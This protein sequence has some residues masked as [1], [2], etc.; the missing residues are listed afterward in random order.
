MDARLRHRW[1][2]PHAQQHIH[3]A[4]ARGRHRHVLSRVLLG[5]HWLPDSPVR[6]AAGPRKLHP[7]LEFPLIGCLP[8][9]D[10]RHGG[11][12]R[13]CAE[14][15]RVQPIRLCQDWW[16]HQG[17]CQCDGRLPGQ[18]AVRER[19]HAPPVEQVLRI[20]EGVAGLHLH[21]MLHL[22]GGDPSPCRRP[23]LHAH[24]LKELRRCHLRALLWRLPVLLRPQCCVGD[25]HRRLL[26]DPAGGRMV[27]V[28]QPGHRLLPAP[29]RH[30]HR[31]RGRRLL[32]LRRP[33]KDLRL[34]P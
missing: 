34:R 28:P 32:W 4:L 2:P 29:L 33:A 31:W 25:P 14:G 16:Q 20:R 9:P 19:L 26:Q 8:V 1:L 5:R 15:N 22:L 18:L 17:R 10:G 11:E 7:I 13:Q 21:D 3:P 12:R 24:E 30:A 27:P 23:R 6:T